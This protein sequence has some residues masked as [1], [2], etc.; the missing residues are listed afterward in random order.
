MRNYRTETGHRGGINSLV[1]P[2]EQNDSYLIS[3]GRDRL[4][5]IWQLNYSKQKATMLANLDSHT[6]WVNQLIFIPQAGNT[7]VS[8]SHD[9][10]IKVWRLDDFSRFTE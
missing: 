7:L 6:D 8:C 3:A 1:C 9:T 5:K 4:I 2:P 10:T